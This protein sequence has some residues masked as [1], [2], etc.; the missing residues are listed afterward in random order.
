MLNLLCT[1]VLSRPACVS[2]CIVRLLNAVSVCLLLT[3]SAA[4]TEMGCIDNTLHLSQ[5]HLKME[6]LVHADF[7]AQYLPY[8]C[9]P[10][11][12]NN[13]RRA[14]TWPTYSN[15]NY[16]NATL[17]NVQFCS[18][19][20]PAP[21]RDEEV[22]QPDKQASSP[23]ALTSESPEKALHHPVNCPKQYTS[24]PINVTSVLALKRGAKSK[25]C[26]H[27]NSPTNCHICGIASCI[28]QPTAAALM[29]LL[30]HDG[31]QCSRF[32]HVQ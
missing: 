32:S 9:L 15:A 7:Q 6:P 29:E 21:T 19:A 22:R 1:F 27:T 24:L 2:L 5:T 26:T 20:L 16:S 31:D 4:T 13:C 12:C 18:H 11:L 8:L 14:T 28:L 10:N 23:H 3:I 30:Q 25:G 17:F